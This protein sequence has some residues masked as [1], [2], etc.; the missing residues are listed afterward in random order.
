MKSQTEF[1]YSNK[2]VCQYEIGQIVPEFAPMNY[3]IK[4][5]F[6]QTSFDIIIGLANPERTYLNESWLNV[7][8]FNYQMIPTIIVT[9]SY[10]QVVG[11]VLLK[12]NSNININDWVNESDDHVNLVIVDDY[13]NSFEVKEIRRIQLPMLKT[14]RSI[15]KKQIECLDG[16][17]DNT[18]KIIERGFPTPWMIYYTDEECQYI[19]ETS[20]ELQ[21]GTYI[22][23][24]PTEKE[25]HVYY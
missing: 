6:N 15:L 11:K 21:T 9:T 8:L 19:K 23:N 24:E 10:I 22:I 13:N 5:S 17:I 18:I 12:S 20:D 16:E 3:E 2:G 1:E 7:S 4:V 25:I 14:I